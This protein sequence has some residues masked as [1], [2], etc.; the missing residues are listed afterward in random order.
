MKQLWPDARGTGTRVSSSRGVTGERTSCRTFDARICASRG[1]AAIL[2]VFLATRAPAQQSASGVSADVGAD[3]G[4]APAAASAAP[5]TTDED[6]RTQYPA[7]LS[8]SYFGLNVGA[9]RYLF[10]GQ[11][12]EPGYHAESLDIPHLAARVDLFG[13]HFSKYLSAQVIYMRPVRYVV[14]KQVNG[15][16]LR[17][18]VSEAFGGLTLVSKLPVTERLSVYGE[19]GWGITSRSGFTI[20]D[21]P[22]LK[23]AHFAAGLL[24]AGLEYHATDSVDVI[25]GATYSPGRKAFDQPSTRLF[26][27]GMRYVMRPLPAA[28]VERNRRSGF[29]F[30][31]NMIRLGYTSNILAYGVND[32]FSRTVPIFWGGHVET[33]RGVTLSYQRNV[34]HTGKRFAFDLGTSASY[35]RSGAKRE[36]FCTLSAYP[37]FRFIAV[38]AQRADIYVNYSLAG[39]TYLTRSVIDERDTGARF[40]FQDLMGVGASFGRARRMNAEIGIKHYSNGNIFTRNAAIKVPLTLTLGLAF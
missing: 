2:I 36:G 1:F 23:D 40:T 38:R 15:A 18:E 11:Q 32:F 3:A 33:K 39:P 22:A 4:R 35:W 37:L 13:H 29:L 12:L 31:A 25:L 5:V 27:T 19:G 16:R 9:I 21:I 6:T 28:R 34:F 10:S 17:G 24:G 14:Y 8:N 26:T 7:F 30:P 20:N